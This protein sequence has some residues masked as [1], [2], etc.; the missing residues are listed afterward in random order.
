MG[1]KASQCHRPV[2]HPQRGSR[3]SYMRP[4]KTFILSG[5]ISKRQMVVV[6]PKWQ[7]RPWWILLKSARRIMLI[8]QH[9]GD[10]F[11]HRLENILDS[12]TPRTERKTVTN[13]SRSLVGMTKLLCQRQ[14]R[15]SSTSWQNIVLGSSTQQRDAACPVTQHRSY[16]AQVSQQ[17]SH[18]FF[19]LTTGGKLSPTTTCKLVQTYLTPLVPDPWNYGSHSCRRGGASAASRQGVQKRLIK[20]HGNWKSDIVDIYIE[21]N[22]RSK[23]EVSLAMLR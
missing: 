6:V 16:K 7:S 3:S 20:A 13:S 19:N 23:L 8:P 21:D 11:A 12:Y 18:Y 15:Q 4:K 14:P 5:H 22:I 1:R 9:L 17:G 10:R 2:L